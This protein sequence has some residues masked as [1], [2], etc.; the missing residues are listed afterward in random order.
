MKTNLNLAKI[1]LDRQDFVSLA[2]TLRF[3]REHCKIDNTSFDDLQRKGTHLLEIYALEIQMYTQTK[4]YKKLKEVYQRCLAVKTAIPHPRIMGIVRECGG[5]MHI[6][7]S[8]KLFHI[9]MDYVSFLEQWDQAQQDFFEA[10]KNYDEAGSPQRIRCL[11]Y[12]VLA[13]MLTESSINPFD[14]QETSSYK[15]HPEL[16]AMM[17]MVIA[18]QEKDI[19]KF[20]RVLQGGLSGLVYLILTLYR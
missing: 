13:N 20:Q 8:K 16:I 14:S 17:D 18:F 2:K 15:S 1:F 3:L 19:I 12:L 6:I 5:K 7:Q 4:N 11:K 9:F 10:F